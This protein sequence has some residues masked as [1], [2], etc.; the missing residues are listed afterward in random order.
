MPAK[1]V[2]SGKL[3]PLSITLIY[4]CPSTQSVSATHSNSCINA[5]SVP[6]TLTS[7]LP[8]RIGPGQLVLPFHPS[9]GGFALITLHTH[10]RHRSAERI[11]YPGVFDSHHGHGTDASYFCPNSSRR[12]FERGVPFLLASRITQAIPIM[13]FTEIT[14]VTSARGQIHISTQGFSE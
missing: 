3:L 12:L 11:R 2:Q 1:A 14:G 6:D 13:S 8:S 9:E 7:L 4:Q 10:F 5:L